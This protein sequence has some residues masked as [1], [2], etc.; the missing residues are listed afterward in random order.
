MTVAP[1][2]A[3]LLA[4]LP[5]KVLTAPE[6]LA[7][8]CGDRSGQSVPGLPLAAVLATSVEDVQAVCRV[9]T[10]HATPLVTR[11]AGTGLSGGA[12]AGTGEVVLDLSGMNRILE[13]NAANRLAVVEPGVINGDLDAVL[14][15]HGLWWAPDP[16]SRAICSVGGNIAMNAGGL[17]CAKY[18]VTREAVLGLK[19]VLADG[20]LISTGRRTVKGV[21]G[22]DLTS[23]M[24]G[25]EGT[26]GVIVEATLKLLPA[27]TGPTPTLGAAFASVAAAA[28]AVTGVSAA[29]LVPAAMEMLDRPSL[30]AIAAHQGTDPAPGAQ[31]YLL[32][33]CDGAAGAAELAAVAAV[34]EEHGGVCTVAASREEGEALFALRR[35]LFPSLEALGGVL[36]V[37]DVAVPK[38]R[39]AEAFTGIREIEARHGVSIPTAAHAGDGNF[40]PTFVVP[41]ADAIPERVWEAA[42]ELFAM[43]LRL[44][45]TLTGEHGI[46]V[47][48]R[49]WLKDELG[50][51]QYELQR[52]IKALFDPLGILNPGKMFQP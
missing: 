33:Q 22:Y 46:G 41:D 36:L 18:G 1:V 26:L 47:L 10:E 9:A 27:V 50:E 42:G 4:V 15:D 17:L 7:A 31:A 49:R 48:K 35:N 6:E 20:R 39:M 45:G 32:V 14:A 12:L 2:V 24:V 5:G 34:I 8:R 38:D 23:L 43:G 11:G 29:G 37:E 30:D 28:S 51:E 52:G 40:H 25:S 13:I 21:T 19:A 3:A 44:G 16:A